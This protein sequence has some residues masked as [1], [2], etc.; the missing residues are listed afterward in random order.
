MPFTPHTPTISEI[1][2]AMP[3]GTP[4]KEA[5]RKHSEGAPQ[6]NYFISLDKLNQ[7]YTVDEG[8]TLSGIAVQLNDLLS[9][10]SD[11]PSNV[12]AGD[13]ALVNKIS[14]PG[15]ISVGQKIDL[16][17]FAGQPAE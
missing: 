13:I 17:S 9:R 12:T 5:L 2:F 3:E 10:T 1:L 8:D 6:N 4:V 14:D 15:K 16:S 7:P 11:E